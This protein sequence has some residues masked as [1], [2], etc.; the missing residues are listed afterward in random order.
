MRLEWNGIRQDQ[1]FFDW[2]LKAYP[3]ARIS[4]AAYTEN[5]PWQGA[6]FKDDILGTVGTKSNRTGNYLWVERSIPKFLTGDNCIQLSADDA[7]DGLCLLM[8]AVEAHF[9]EWFVFANPRQNVSCKR[10]D[11]F[12]Q[13]RTECSGE[14]FAHIARSLKNRKVALHLTG[15]EIHQNRWEHARFYEKGLE[16]GNEQYLNV[17]RHEEQLRGPKIPALVDVQTLKINP[18]AVQAFMNRRFS[19]WSPQAECYGFEQLMQEHGFRGAATVGLVLMPELD[20]VYRRMLSKDAYYRCR[21]LALNAR[22]Q[23]SK[24][25]LSIPENAWATTR[26]YE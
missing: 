25:D 16:S 23:M 1:E 18:P 6:M 3:T 13:R 11:F 17:I 19:D 21:K 20:A 12:Y 2:L 7:R 9:K 5:M 15:V 14:V 24:L 8:N 4:Y 26:P 22:R 10:V